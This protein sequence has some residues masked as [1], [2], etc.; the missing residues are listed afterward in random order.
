MPEI[1]NRMFGQL[2]RKEPAKLPSECPLCGQVSHQSPFLSCDERQLQN[3]LDEDQPNWES[4]HW[5]TE[6]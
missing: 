6:A 2:M 4:E 5:P 1:I 3:E